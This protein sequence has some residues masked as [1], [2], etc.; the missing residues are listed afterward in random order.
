M[1]PMK[2][3]N[4]LVAFALEVT[5]L[6]VYGYYGYQLGGKPWQKLLLAA[7]F[8]GVMALVWG[9]YLAPR[10][11]GRL[12]MPMLLVAKL[13]VMGTAFAMLLDLGRSTQAVLFGIILVIHYSFAVLWKQV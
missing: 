10:A 9:R 3:L 4:D 12:V 13:L 7:V 2:V 11:Q 5:A 1:E 8:M 6:V